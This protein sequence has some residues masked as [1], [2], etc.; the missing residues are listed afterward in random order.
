M[1]RRKTGQI[2]PEEKLWSYSENKEGLHP[3]KIRVTHHR[4]SRY[5]SVI[6]PD[7]SKMFLSEE[8]Y[9]RIRPNPNKSTD[10]DTKEKSKE[11]R[12]T[13]EEKELIAIID[14]NKTRIKDAINEVTAYNRKS[15]SFAEFERK[16]LGENADKNFLKFFKLHIERLEK[17]GQAGTVRTYNSSLSALVEFQR[18]RDFD[19][20][21]LTVQKLENFD[22]W[23]RTPR[24]KKSNPKLLTKPLN[25]TSVSIYMRCIRAVYNEMAINDEYLLSIYPFSKKDSDRRYKIPTGGGGQKGIT[26]DLEEIKK[27]I[28]GK[29]IGDEIPENPMYRAK[30]LFMFSFYAQGI[31]FK[32]MALLKYSDIGKETI[33]IKRQKTIRTK[34]DPKTIRIPLHDELKELLIEQGSPNKK[35]SNFVFE[36]FDADSKY[37]PKEM[38][39]TI[40]QWV[41]VTNKWLKKYCDH[42]KLPVVSTYSARH[43]FASNAKNHLS[44]AQISEMLN[45][46]RVTTTQVYL[47]RFPDEQNREGL[48]KVF[49]EIKKTQA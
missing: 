42:N 22:N 29:V 34:K 6:N 23:L 45:H 11:K 13:R 3:V 21:D 39:E 44:I 41:K 7:T 19:P 12:L 43:T 48:M 14:D 40:R 31:N 17:K 8:Q 32:D 18:G 49:G 36:L 38:D 35:K 47:G 30:R 16:Y 1:A 25:D 4:I 10:G 28:Y 37:T 5:Y 9:E 46:S 2:L 27:F 15:F 26:L 20:A 33:N 24:P